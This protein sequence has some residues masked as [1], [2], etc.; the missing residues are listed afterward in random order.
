MSLRVLDANG[1]GDVASAVEAIDYAAA[2]GARVINCSWGTDAESLALR[3][4][5][6]RA[7]QHVVV[8][9]SAGNSAHDLETTP[10]FPASFDPPNLISVASSDKFDNLAQFSNW[11]ATKVTLAAPGTGILTTQVGGDYWLVS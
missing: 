8:V 4:A 3:D 1:T 2:Q 7:G 10:Y 11:G 6:E 9:A 5:I